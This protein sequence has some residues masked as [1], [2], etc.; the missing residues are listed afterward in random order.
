MFL[1]KLFINQDLKEGDYVDYFYLGEKYR[2][3]V[4]NILDS[5]ELELEVCLDKI[6]CTKS[7]IKT[8][9]SSVKKL[10]FTETE[11]E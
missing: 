2:G 1:N 4:L 7:V 10:A 8:A 11:E 9:I 3:R 6:K 5:K